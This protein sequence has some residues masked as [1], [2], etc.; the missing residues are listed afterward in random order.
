MAGALR[1]TRSLY[2]LLSGFDRCASTCQGS[3]ACGARGV[4]R[5]DGAQIAPLHAPQLVRAPS[6]PQILMLWEL[7]SY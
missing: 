3:Y 7:K 6:G 1:E 2:I 5:G 4:A